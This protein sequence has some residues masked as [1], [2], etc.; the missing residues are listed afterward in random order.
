[1]PE[2]PGAAGRR[3]ATGRQRVREE[4]VMRGVRRLAMVAGLL[5]VAMVLAACGGDDGGDGG[6]G[7]TGA[8]TSGGTGGG[9][10]AITIQGFAFRPSTLQVS[11]ETTLTITNDDS[12][13]HSFT[14]D[15]GSV[16][17]EIAAG[18]TVDVTV[19]LSQTT[20][21]H[22]RF[23]SSMTGSLEVT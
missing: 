20:G 3:W 17:Q 19:D 7:G 12:V 23:H 21:F 1:M 22:C 6:G 11:G 9:G 4:D 14:L 10:T 8:T 18:E 2:A 15:D 16:D 5:A 13:T